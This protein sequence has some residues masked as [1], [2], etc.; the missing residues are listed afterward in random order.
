MLPWK[1]FLKSD[2]TSYHEF[3]NNSEAIIPKKEYYK[4]EMQNLG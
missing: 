1:S 4:A 3:K 2:Q